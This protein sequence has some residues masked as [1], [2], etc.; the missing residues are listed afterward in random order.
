MPAKKRFFK[1][2]KKK[3]GNS[4]VNIR[5]KG[6]D[7]KDPQKNKEKVVLKVN[8]QD[9][10]KNSQ[11]ITERSQGK[12]ISKPIEKKTWQF[13]LIFVS[14]FFTGLASLIGCLFLGNALII[15]YQVF[16]KRVALQQE[17]RLWEDISKKYPSYRDADFQVAILAYRLGDKGKEQ[18]Y[19]TKTLA[20][21]PNFEPAKK[22]AK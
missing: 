4:S 22:L 7:G 5:E 12:P 15:L 3:L 6:R 9:L 1:N 13:W 21:D 17:M 19:I 14:I 2:T 11:T 20:I 16:S 18:E 8:T 10:P